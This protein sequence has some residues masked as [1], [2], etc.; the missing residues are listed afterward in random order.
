MKIVNAVMQLLLR[1]SEDRSQQV[2]LWWSKTADFNRNWTTL[3][4]L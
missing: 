3:R 4:I 1:K 2:K